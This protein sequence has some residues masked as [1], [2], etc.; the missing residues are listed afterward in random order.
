MCIMYIFLES[1]MAITEHNEIRNLIIISI[2]QVED[3]SMSV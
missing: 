2:T 1:Q 3:Q